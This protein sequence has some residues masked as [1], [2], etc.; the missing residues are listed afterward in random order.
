MF[1]EATT[2]KLVNASTA[3]DTAYT[4]YYD[5]LISIA[6]IKGCLKDLYRDD[7][8]DGLED[9]CVEDAIKKCRLTIAGANAIAMV[10]SQI[11][12]YSA[13]DYRGINI[14]KLCTDL[15]ALCEYHTAVKELAPVEIVA[16]RQIGLDYD[17]VN[18]DWDTVNDNIAAAERINTLL[19]GNIT[20][21]NYIGIC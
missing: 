20:P 19:S 16:K 7:C 12:P 8:L 11:A 1:G 9:T 18:T 3:K 10:Y 14:E 4:G 21:K 2:N 6:G 13:Q 5:S 15:K 17:G